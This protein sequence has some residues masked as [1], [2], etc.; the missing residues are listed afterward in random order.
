MSILPCSGGSMRMTDRL[1]WFLGLVCF[2]AVGLP[3]SAS[4]AELSFQSDTIFRSFS[5]DPATESDA[6][7]FPAYE[8]LQVDIE[9]PEEPGL[10]FHLYGWGRADVADNDYF[11]ETTGGELVYGYLEFSGEQARFNARLGRQYVFEGVANESID[12]LRLSSDLGKYFSGSV[13]AGQPVALS[14]ENGRGGDSIYG[15]RVA[16]HLVGK[17]DLGIS[18]KKINSDGEDA[19]ETAG[20]DLSAYLPGGVNLFG[21]STYNLEYD[22]WGEHSYELRFNLGSTTIRPYFQKFQYADYFGI[23][24]GTVN[25]FGLLVAGDEELT[26]LGTDLT[27]P[28]GDSWV[29]VGKAKHYDYQQ[30]DDSSQYFAMQGTWTSEENNQI[31]GEIGVMNGDTAQTKYTMV[32][33][34]TYQDHMPDGCPLGFFSSDLVYV[35]YDQ[36]IYGEDSSLFISLASGKKF[37]ED[38]LEVKI[39]GDYS[40]DP[41]FDEDV[42]GMLILSYHFDHAL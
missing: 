14:E 10:A 40:K 26:V 15:A 22:G 11:T 38:A 31:G 42:R 37:M 3:L 21:Y 30:L 34:F 4:A 24:G 12:G 17:Y 29:L 41:Y 35:S 32:R 1:G 8:Y 6:A 39:S 19:G 27:V 2:F 5:R 16:N 7:V 18:Y 20:I 25:P 9:T 33:L 36:E 23:A 28:V 13:Y